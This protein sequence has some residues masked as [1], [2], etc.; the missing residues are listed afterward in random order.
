MKVQWNDTDVAAE[1]ISAG[2]QFA[3]VGAPGRG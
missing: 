1:K 2:L 3:G